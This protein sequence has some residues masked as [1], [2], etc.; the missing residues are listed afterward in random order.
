MEEFYLFCMSY[1]LIYII[2]QIFIILPHKKNK[3]NRNKKNR[4][5]LLEIKYLEVVYKLDVEKIKYEQLL[6]ICGLVSSFDMAI[7]VTIVCLTNGF[8]LEIIFGMISMIIL[9]F[10]SYHFVYLF[11]KKKGMIKNGKHK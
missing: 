6:Q 11:Y 1:V 8:L 4:K 3:N 10:L 5:E 9:I 2:Y 7:V